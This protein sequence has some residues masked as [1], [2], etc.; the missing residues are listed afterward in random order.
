MW[1]LQ[2]ITLLSIPSKVFVQVIMGQNDASEYR[3]R[4]CSLRS[5]DLFI[6]QSTK[7]GKNTVGLIT[8]G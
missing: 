5:I 6:T 8:V 4:P 2:L 7:F 1:K 3:C